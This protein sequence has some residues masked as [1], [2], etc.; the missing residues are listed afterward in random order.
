MSNQNIFNRRKSGYGK[1]LLIIP[2][3]LLIFF[4]GIWMN[5]DD[6]EKVIS[7][8]QEVNATVRVGETSKNTSKKT[9]V[10]STGTSAILDSEEKNSQAD[11]K[12]EVLNRQTEA[13]YLLKEVEGRVKLFYYDE[14]GKETL[15]SETDIAYMLISENDQNLFKE[16]I[17]VKDLEELNELLQDFES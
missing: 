13:Y 7:E 8:N 17:I 10:S 4:F 5:S 6:E 1:Y 9:G 3:L 12:N 16:G 15:V 11:D 14:D 2:A